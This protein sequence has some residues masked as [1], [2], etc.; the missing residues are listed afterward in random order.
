[1][2]SPTISIKT[3]LCEGHLAVV[4]RDGP[5]RSVW[6][7]FLHQLAQG[8]EDSTRPIVSRRF[9]FKVE[10]RA[11]GGSG[12]LMRIMSPL[13][14]VG[15]HRTCASPLFDGTPSGSRSIRIHGRILVFIVVRFHSYITNSQQL[16]LFQGTTIAH[17]A[18]VF[19]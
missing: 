11:G 13:L 15:G 1:M 7:S 16:I 18:K 6:Q 14:L 3:F 17:R 10:F 19:P 9:V 12:I 4:C 8:N 5:F 2:A